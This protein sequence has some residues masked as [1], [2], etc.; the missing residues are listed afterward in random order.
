VAAAT[1]V[2]AGLVLEKA[3]IRQIPRED[4]MQDSLT[5]KTSLAHIGFTRLDPIL[6]EI[7]QVRHQVEKDCQD[8]SQI[9]SEIFISSPEIFNRVLYSEQLVCR[10][11]QPAL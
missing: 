2:L 1:S 4:L 6:G 10:S 7:R 11:P 8:N 9:L 3:V 5:L